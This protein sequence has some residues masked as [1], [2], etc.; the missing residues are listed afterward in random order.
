MGST[1]DKLCEEYRSVPDLPTEL[2]RIKP[3]KWLFDYPVRLSIDWVTLAV[4][5]D[6]GHVE[7]FSDFLKYRFGSKAKRRTYDDTEYYFAKYYGH[8][9]KYWFCQFSRIRRYFFIRIGHPNA[10]VLSQLEADFSDNYM[11]SAIELSFDL[12][13]AHHKAAKVKRALRRNLYLSWRGQEL[14]FGDDVTTIYI[15]N[16]RTC[17]RKAVRCYPKR[18]ANAY[19]IEMILRRPFFNSLPTKAFPV[20]VALTW[21]EGFRYLSL[22]YFDCLAFYHAFLKYTRRPAAQARYVALNNIA[23]ISQQIDALGLNA[24]VKLARQTLKAE[25]ERSGIDLNGNC[26]PDIVKVHPHDYLLRE[27]LSKGKTLLPLD[28]DCRQLLQRIMNRIGSSS[29]LTWRDNLC[30]TLLSAYHLDLTEYTGGD[31]M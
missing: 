18:K 14:Y 3:L 7:T 27:A 23:T 13:G 1:L 28:A 2:T 6:E 4:W 21:Q 11:I 29:D 5:A 16:P 25:A 15:D 12:L 24:G 9:V 19:R 20:L 31:A 22:R 26:F 30:R 10:K 17:R 8:P